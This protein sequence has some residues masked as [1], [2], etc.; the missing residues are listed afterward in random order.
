MREEARAKP[1]N[2]QIIAYTQSRLSKFAQTVMTWSSGRGTKFT[3]A[4]LETGGKAIGAAVVLKLT[5][6]LPE[7]YAVVAAAAKFVAVI[8]RSIPG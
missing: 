5:A 4:V 8:A 1:P 2:P 7:V 3:D 6:I